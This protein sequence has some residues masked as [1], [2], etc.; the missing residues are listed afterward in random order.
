MHFWQTSCETGRSES[1]F[2]MPFNEQKKEPRK[3]RRQVLG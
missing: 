3:D 1:I 2:G